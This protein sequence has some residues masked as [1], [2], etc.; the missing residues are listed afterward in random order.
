[1]ALAFFKRIKARRG[2]LKGRHPLR[3]ALL[4]VGG[5]GVLYAA[6][7]AVLG[8]AGAVPTAP[9]FFGLDADNYYFWQMAWA[10]P[11][12]LAVWVLA[13]GVLLALGKKERG[14]TAVLS[15]AAWA[16]G[17]PLLVAWVP[18]AI[19]AGFMGL[20]MGQEE[21]VGILSQPGIW[22]TLY[23]AFYAGAAALAVRGF[24]LAGRLVR[25]KSW[26]GAVLAGIAASAVAIGAYVAFIR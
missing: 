26:L 5:V 25:K 8:I 3:R 21:W 16:W 10:V 4:F 14:R 24:I 22:Q 11:L 18:S 19:Q 7:S 17:G 6:T 12:V 20:G 13:S 1:V 23:L 9:V 2:F 15:E